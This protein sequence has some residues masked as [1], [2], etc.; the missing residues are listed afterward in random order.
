[1][2]AVP[3]ILVVEDNP[4]TRKMLRLTLVTEGYTVVEAADARA[5]VAAAEKALPDLVLQDLI[6]PDMDGLELLRRL[7]AL[8][9]GTELPI[10]ALSGFLSR[11]E[12]AQAGHEGFSALLVKPIEPSRLLEAIRVC[13]PPPPALEASAGDRRRLLIVDDDPVQL[14][15]AR[16]HL[17]QLGFDVS[18][19]SGASDARIAARANRPDLI[20]S[21]VFMPGT[22]GFEL[23][24][25]IRRDPNLANVPVVLFSAQY[26]SQADEDLARR[27]GASALVV[28]T[29]DFGN[30]APAIVR[31]LQARAPIPAEQ[32]S[33]QLALR[34]ARLV[35]HQLERQAATTAG[36]AQRCGIQAAQ[37][38]LLSGVAEA[39]TRKSDP[40]VALR[41]VLAATLDAAGISKGA[42]ILRDAA[43]ML[44][45]RHDIGF[46]PSER[47][48]LQK[49]FGHGAL[50]EQLVNRGGSV[51]VPSQAIPDDAA[52]DILAGANVAVAQIVP[53]IS[54]GRGVGAMI[55]GGTG[56]D[57]TGDD[58]VAFAR[59]MGNQVVQSLE[60]ARSVARLTASDQRYRTLLERA[61]D[62]IA[63]LTPDGI[64][65]EMNHRWV[66]FTGLPREQLIGR[67]VR[68]FAPSGKEEE[69]VQTYNEAVA[70]N[71]ARTPPVEIARPDGPSAFIE[72]SSTNVDVGGERLVFTIGRDV[73]ERRQAV[74]A[75]RTAEERM[76]FALQNAGVGIWD[77]DY[78]TGVLRWSETIQVHYGLQPGTFGG[79]F[80]AFV[81]HIHP[82]DRASVLETVGKAMK[83][84]A[85][86]SV[87]NRSM[88]QDGTI[89]WLS[90]VGRVLLGANGKPV[91][92]V[93]ISQDVTER[94]RAEAELAHLND[95]I[96]LQRLRVFRATMTTVQDIVNNLLNGFQ[97]VRLEAEEHLPP[98]IL[99]LV[100]QMIQR[101]SMKLTA[102]GDLETV[103]E[104]EMAV[105]LGIDYPGAAS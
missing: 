90:G 57:V 77:M 9:D 49:F 55:I 102:L 76:R 20:L 34:H 54:D 16:I 88:W 45:L 89:R 87:L 10:L 83:S 17:S 72:F 79:T 64:V 96:Q 60:L 80:E 39:L 59:A 74:E 98:E 30:V 84:G 19:V 24:L 42:L 21:D 82:D 27:V 5:A 33:D 31:A 47:S 22:D 93:G 50:L 53:L 11:L 65:R 91:R 69:T 26:G 8:P 23:C 32:P 97:L 56:T 104:K 35:I 58:S 40:D 43:G 62:F 73:T 92:A 41:D 100:D 2:T 85:D 70:T 101:A 95:E 1:M 66:E 6:L 103:K 29:P 14:K 105:G 75:L 46:S 25:E 4:T 81:E 44:E 63:V 61:T 36:L 3:S 18:A 86:F 37:L 68:D 71:A 94:R 7:R 15:L 78:T 28:R 38:S 67:H 13:L 99:T 48:E 52:R 51:P 12:E